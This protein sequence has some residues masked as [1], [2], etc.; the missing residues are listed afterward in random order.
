MGKCPPAIKRLLTAFGKDG[1]RDILFG[2]ESATYQVSDFGGDGNPVALGKAPDGLKQRPL[3][4]YIDSRI[5]G[6]HQFT[7]TYCNTSDVPD[8]TALDR[9]KI[10]MNRDC[11]GNPRR[12]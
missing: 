3:Q 10:L 1:K 5:F 6:W 9:F 12:G 11:V 4:N 8:S 2:L 7:K